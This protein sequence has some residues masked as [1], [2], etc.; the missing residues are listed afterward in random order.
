MTRVLVVM[1]DLDD[2]LN[3]LAGP[4]VDAGLQLDTWAT[5]VDKRPAREPSEYAAI[6]S[7]GAVAGVEDHQFHPWMSVEMEYFEHCLAANKPI[8]GVCF[9]SQLL[10]KV[11]GGTVFKAAT[12][13]VGW[14]DVVAT[15][16]AAT[17]RLVARLGSTYDG[18]QFHYD[19]FT[20]PAEAVVLARTGELIEA[21]R[22]GERA[23]GLQYHVEANPGVASCWLGAY[24]DEIRAAGVDGDDL[25]AQTAAKWRT[26]R[27]HC[28][29]IA[30]EFAAVVKESVD[31]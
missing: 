26:Y 1:H 6:V 10:A 4:L 22:V 18:F 17:D 15:P 14:T 29:A 12:P 30:T 20:L 19:T 23:W 28:W 21:F 24:S 25:M 3:E 8:L 5:F 7:M 2:H 9:G 27:E 31:A 16:E 11:V 13:E